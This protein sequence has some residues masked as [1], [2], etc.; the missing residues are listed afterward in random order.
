[1]EWV[2]ESHPQDDDFKYL[3]GGCWAVSCEILGPPF[4][5]YVASPKNSSSASRQSDIFGFR[6]ARDSNGSMPERSPAVAGREK[7]I[8]PLCGR[9][10]VDFQLRDIKVPENNIY[11][12]IGYFDIE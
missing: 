2:N 9:E 5:H 7:D 8:C 12:W 10:F 6:C 1:M 11:T 4:F 3:R